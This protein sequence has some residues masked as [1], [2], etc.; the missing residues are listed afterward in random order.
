[1]NTCD[2]G[3]LSLPAELFSFGLR[4]G[5]P[6]ITIIKNR[7]AHEDTVRS[8]LAGVHTRDAPYSARRGPRRRAQTWRALFSA[9]CVYLTRPPKAFISPSAPRVC[10][11]SR[12]T[13]GRTLSP[14]AAAGGVRRYD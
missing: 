3:R 8:P 14:C 4:D 5:P 2:S 12:L 10:P 1:M 11:D 13:R 9:P 6:W 7:P